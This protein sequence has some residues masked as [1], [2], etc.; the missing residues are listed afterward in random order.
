MRQT[1][2]FNT[3]EAI[4]L[5]A[6]RRNGDLRIYEFGNC[7]LY[8]ESAIDAER[9]LAPYSE[10]YRL[11]I[12]V[13]GAAS[14]TSWREK[15]VEASF[16]TL[17]DMVERVL[18][19]FGI[20]I[21]SLK[22]ESVKSGLYS[23]AQSLKLNGKELLQMGV[24]SAKLRGDFGIKSDVFYAEVDF[25]AV[26]KSTKKQKITVTELSKYPEVKRD[27]AL[28]IDKGVTFSSLREVALQTE[29]KLLKSVTLFDVYEGD[30]L[31]AG[32][33]S[34]ALGFTLEDKTQTLTDKVIDKVM[35]NLQRQLET[36]CGAQVRS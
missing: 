16:F 5:N 23:E 35:N 4:E 21:Y 25:D 19:R 26:V 12:A 30:K 24:V 7:Y 11:A 36:K 31:P 15:G 10:S 3:L 17:R 20:D 1:L 9:P 29:R 8:N 33:K 18:R 6:N 2:L 14:P 32:K 27:L 22:E 34:Y 13:T 28:L